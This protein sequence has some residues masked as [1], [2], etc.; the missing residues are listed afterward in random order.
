ML[1]YKI[2]NTL[3]FYCSPNFFSHI[4]LKTYDDSTGQIDR[5]LRWTEF[6][7]DKNHQRAVRGKFW[8]IFADLQ[9]VVNDHLQ[10]QLCIRIIGHLN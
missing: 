10:G 6:G 8:H 1:L 9:Q 7:G 4:S 5:V 3:Y 2:K